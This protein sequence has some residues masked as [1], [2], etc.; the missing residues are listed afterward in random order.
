MHLA[1]LVCLA[2]IYT[3]AD[4]FEGVW[5][6]MTELVWC[7]QLHAKVCRMNSFTASEARLPFKLSQDLSPG[8]QQTRSVC[9]F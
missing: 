8:A 4:H 3:N 7:L 2:L 6:Y 9:L 1:S 5:P